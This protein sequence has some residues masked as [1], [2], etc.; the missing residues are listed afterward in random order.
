MARINRPSHLLSTEFAS[1]RTGIAAA[2]TE[3]LSASA[4]FA[5]LSKAWAVVTAALFSLASGTQA[6]T[7]GKL[8]EIEEV[9][10]YGTKQGL[11]LQEVDVSVEMFDAERIEQ[12]SLFDLD[13]LLFRTPNVQT[14]GS[15]ADFSIRGISRFGAGGA[16]QGVT[17]NVY[18]DGAPITSI[19]LSYGFDSLWDLAQ[20]EV[21]RGPQSTVQG[22]NA[23][24]GA[25]V[26]R[27][28]DPTF[29]WEARA[30]ARVASFNTQQYA[31][32]LSGPLIEDELAFR[33]SADY[34]TTDGFITNGFTGRDDNARENTL[35]RGK[36]RWTPA[37]VPAL[38]ARLLLDYNSSTVG[39][40]SYRVFSNFA[41][42]D[43]AFLTD[44]DYNDHISYI[45]QEVSD[46]ETLRTI[47]DL[48]YALNPNLTLKTIFT[49]EN[50]D[51]DRVLGDPDNPGQID[52]VVNEDLVNEQ[53]T[54][55]YSAEVRL[56]FLKDKWSGSV[57]AYYFLDD[58]TLDT[59][60]FSPFLGSVFFSIDPIT[61]LIVGTSF[62]ETRTENH[63]V[64]A[65]VRYDLNEHWT[66]D[67]SARYDRESFETSEESSV[68]TLDPLDC[69]A[70]LPDF[71]RE[72]LEVPSNDIACIDLVILVTD[73]Q[74][75]LPEQDETY[76][77]FLP[78]A[79]VTYNVNDDLAL[80]ASAQ[81]GYR[82]GGTFLQLTLAGNIVRS[83]DPEFLTNYELG[84]RS[85]W[86]DQRLTVNGNLFYGILEDQQVRIPGPSGGFTDEEI[87][88]A[89]ETTLQG[90]E[91]SFEFA[92]T[93]ELELFGSLG[94][95]DATF[96][97]F[98]FAA[99]GLPFDNLAGNN[100]PRSPSTSFS[101]GANYLHG[102]G[103]FANATLSYAGP[104]DSTITNF[105][106]SDLGPGLTERVGSRTLVNARVG[107]KGQNFMLQI[108]A[109]NLLD[110]DQLASNFL[111]NVGPDTGN[112]VYRPAPLANVL[113]PQAVG[114][115]I[116]W[117][118]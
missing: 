62:T 51:L 79:A 70:T 34:Q 9:I 12:E 77:A 118:L 108:Y 59:I 84:F 90:L 105:D 44:F 74:E 48:S 55:T 43:P 1:H 23:L 37:A 52:S 82:A 117:A 50:N 93:A 100:L 94:L 73:A 16:G 33:V 87:V 30:R 39:P 86:L 107:Y 31:G 99:P 41:A 101:L 6:Q 92:A 2:R 83:Y 49:Y 115:G 58:E 88:N 116:D 78:R 112:I 98:P 65:Q 14:S 69:R 96:D 42:D 110:E 113:A 45:S 22:R 104:Q 35:L 36:L 89:G 19:A 25:I 40:Q 61:T 76:D 5:D 103:F 66:F 111:A 67:L 64:Y 8:P 7:L 38:D 57:G 26:M 29:D 95:L 27:T 109:T 53:D 54:K 18:I 46:N 114:L 10:I 21:L 3:R 71:L 80:F 102:S 11:T 91:M 85:Q 15:T 17:F 63:A 97:D 72:L 75:E 56:E 60:F 13:D 24:A 20:V 4:C 28:S 81:R 32:V 68:P 47:A 106:E